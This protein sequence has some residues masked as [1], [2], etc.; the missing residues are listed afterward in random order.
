M[1]ECA[2][3]KKKSYRIFRSNITN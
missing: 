3:R 2:K 1:K